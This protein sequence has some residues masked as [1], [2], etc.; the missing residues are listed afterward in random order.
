MARYLKMDLKGKDNSIRKWVVIVSIQTVF[1]LFIC[2]WAI[3]QKVEVD[4]QK[5]LAV[6]AKE[7]AL[8]AQKEAEEQ[9]K[10]ADIAKALAMD[11]HQEALKYK[12]LY[13][14]E[15]LLNQKK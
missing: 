8:K 11:E 7:F 2:I 5:D 6:M 9:K 12:D 13:E 14:L 1:M 4:K 10:L 3:T 15:K